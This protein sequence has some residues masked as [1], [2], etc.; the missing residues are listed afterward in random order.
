MMTLLKSSLES[1]PL[2]HQ[3][4]V[5]DIY[6]IDQRK[7]L[8][9]TT[10]RL[11]AFDV[12][13][14]EPIPY[15]GEVLTR[16]A[17]FWFD[18]FKDIPNHLTHEN[19]EDYVLPDEIRQVKGRA[20]VVKKLIPI[21]IEAIVRGY[22][23]G[24]GWKE[25]QLSQTICGIGLPEGLKQADRL[26]QVLFTPSNKAEQGQHDEN[27]TLD[28]C[29]K[30]I[31][32]D[33]TQ[34]V[35]DISIEIYSKAAALAK[36]KGIIIA[37]TKFEFGLDSDNQVTLMDEV[38]TPDSSRFWPEESYQVG[39]SPP[40]FDKQY[41]RDWLESQTWNKKA[42]APKLPKNV[43]DETSQKYIEA[44]FKITGKGLS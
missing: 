1:L 13:M 3:G 8:I 25:Y 43:I 24:S 28:Q 40:S 10:D 22:I 7:M 44:F 34:K 4:K 41:V 39:V 9:V 35:S 33:L 31:G 37:D 11:S 14:G 42:P 6:D 26:P 19:P 36:A 18:Y 16:M 21:P 17:N 15:K 20:I 12:I 32:D 38:L 27:I 23:I 5:R 30:L 29:R 2:I